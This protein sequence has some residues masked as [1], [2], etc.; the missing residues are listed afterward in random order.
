MG[1]LPFL[2]GAN[3]ASLHAWLMRLMAHYDV[4]EAAREGCVQ[5]VWLVLVQEQRLLDL[6]TGGPEFAAWLRAVARN[7]AMDAHRRAAR[8]GFVSLDEH[9]DILDHAAGPTDGRD[10]EAESGKARMLAQVEA[11]LQGFS[12]VNRTI[13]LQHARDG[14]TFAEI[15]KSL[16]L[17]EGQARARYDRALHRT[18]R[19]LG[20]K[21]MHVCTGGVSPRPRPGPNERESGSRRANHAYGKFSGDFLKIFMAFTH[22]GLR[23]PGWHD[24]SAGEIPR[25]RT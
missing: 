19:R 16:G 8:D 10:P 4:P 24:A 3:F 6:A 2:D 1:Q 12:E 15:G 11:A 5:E 20:V 9:R 18:Q 22:K 21:A 14:L 17:T 25:C 23:G 13:F 7:K